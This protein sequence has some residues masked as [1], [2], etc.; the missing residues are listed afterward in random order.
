[1]KGYSARAI[2]MIL[3]TV[4][5][6]ILGA[7]LPELLAQIQEGSMEPGYAAMNSVELTL[8]SGDSRYLKDAISLV[9]N[10]IHTLEVSEEVATRSREEILQL[11]PKLLQPYLDRNLILAP[12]LDVKEMTY[13][14]LPYLTVSE[15][16]AASSAVLWEVLILFDEEE[17]ALRLGIEDQ[18]GALV[19]LDFH[20]GKTE[21]S[22]SG[23]DY[24][25]P[26]ETLRTLCSIYLDGLG[27]EFADQVPEDIQAHITSDGVYAQHW[28]FSWEGAFGPA[29]ISFDVWPN[30]IT[31]SIF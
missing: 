2:L 23:I 26:D 27:S 7:L 17:P 25:L 21:A 18:T 24:F 13:S 1:M 5:V 16:E 15:G 8:R 20:S 10:S 12:G 22:I 4:A 29:G 9:S 11:V 6:V 31:V 3:L 19:M 28:N 14:C 30:G